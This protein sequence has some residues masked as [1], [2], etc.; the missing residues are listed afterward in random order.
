ML[1]RLKLENFKAWQGEQ[2]GQASVVVRAGA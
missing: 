1:R 2:V